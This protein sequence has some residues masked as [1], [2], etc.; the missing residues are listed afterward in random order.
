MNTFFRRAISPNGKYF[1]GGFRPANYPLAEHSIPVLEKRE[2]GRI[3][4]GTARG[5]RRPIPGDSTKFPK[6]SR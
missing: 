2:F 6:Y 1:F 5:F 4:E 3:A